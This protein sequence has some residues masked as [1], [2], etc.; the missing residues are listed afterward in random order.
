MILVLNT[1]DLKLGQ[2]IIVW[3]RADGINPSDNISPKNLKINSPHVDDK[4]LSN[5]IIDVNYAVGLL[6]IEALWVPVF[7]AST[8]PLDQTS[9]FGG[10]VS[11]EESEYPSSSLKDSARAVK[12]DLKSSLIDGS[13]SYY[14]GPSVMLG[15]D[16]GAVDETQAANV[17]SLLRVALGKQQVFIIY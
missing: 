9:L 3:G 7:K 14:Y 5:F 1:L 11:F 8:L 17:Y 2:Q 13:L 10:A 4:R 16:L 15:L 6:E 12:I